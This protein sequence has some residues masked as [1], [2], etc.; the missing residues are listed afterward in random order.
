MSIPEYTQGYPPDGSSLG[1]TKIQ[2]RDNLDGT[3]LTLGVDH[4]NNNG[5]PGDNPAGYH[6]LIHMVVQTAT[7]S[8]ITG[9]TQLFA[10][11]P[12]VLVNP[13]T[14][15]PN[16]IP[17]GSDNQLFLLTGG[18]SFCQMTG[19][20]SAQNGYVWCGGLLIQWGTYAAVGGNFPAGSSY[21]GNA[22]QTSVMYPV[23]YPNNVYFGVASPTISFS[24]K[25]NSQ[26]SVNMRSSTFNAGAASSFDWQFY[27]NSA[28]YTGFFWV[29]IGI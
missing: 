6:N 2:I 26:G 27:T 12:S 15:I 8:N 29:T 18:N 9:I 25:P 3:F 5:L 11:N 20:S 22:S 4:I 17:S 23:P 10:G 13:N 21:S 14:G 19:R 24:A 28:D 1:Q 7:P 16:G